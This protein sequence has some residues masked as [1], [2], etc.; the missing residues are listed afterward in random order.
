MV[1]RGDRINGSEQFILDQKYRE[2]ITIKR[3]EKGKQIRFL[4]F[5]MRYGNQELLWEKEPF[6]TSQ[7]KIFVNIDFF[8]ALLAAIR[9]IKPGD[10]MI[11][12]FT[13]RNVEGIFLS[14]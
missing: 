12:A 11:A 7:A 5:R 3:F 9:C 8:L 1:I 2:Q 4:R 10:R 6:F 13:K 14:A